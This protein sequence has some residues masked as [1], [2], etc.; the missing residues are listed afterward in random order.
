MNLIN[1]LASISPIWTWVLGSILVALALFLAFVIAKQPGKEGGLS[2]TIVGN[3]ETY[4]GKNK[5]GDKEAI[6]ARL[7]II[8]SVIFVILIAVLVIVV[9]NTDFTPKA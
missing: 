2:G 1:L 9:K 4:F 8:G 5:G 7:T 3:S 6:Y